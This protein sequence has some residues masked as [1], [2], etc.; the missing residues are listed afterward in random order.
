MPRFPKGSGTSGNPGGLTKTTAPLPGP[1]ATDLEVMRWVWDNPGKGK[2]G[3]RTASLDDVRAAD[4]KKFWEELK[5]G[6]A[7]KKAALA[8]SSAPA[9]P[10]GD[11]VADAPKSSPPTPGP[12]ED[13]PSEAVEALC[14]KLLERL[15]REAGERTK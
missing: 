15:A 3:T 5:A 6:E 14:R 4:P 8:S 12:L 10:S 9:A 13:Q 2:P 1:D 7:A 11:G